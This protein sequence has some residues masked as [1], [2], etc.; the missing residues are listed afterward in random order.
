[1]ITSMISSLVAVALLATVPIGLRV[2]G[3]PAH[4]HAALARGAAA[5]S[6]LLPQGPLAG[7]LAVGW[8][9]AAVHLSWIR[10]GASL[11]TRAALAWLPA[12]AGWLV[13][14]RFGIP[15]LGFSSQIVALT[16]AHFHHAGFIVSALLSRVGAHR[17]L[18]VHQVGMVL[19]AAGITASDALEPLGAVCIVCALMVWTSVAWQRRSACSGWRRR[20]LTVSALAWL[21][22]MLLA[23]VWALAPF[24]P[25]VLVAPLTRTLSAMVAQHGAINAILLV[26]LGL[27]GL[28]PAASDGNPSSTRRQALT[29]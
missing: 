3:T 5:A 21:Y 11:P 1:M 23:L 27:V 17:A 22:P 13:A 9:L 29:R 4:R 19:V 26:L 24:G 8:L 15:P 25:G 16:A 6:L 2:L 14:D 20:A 18:A 12:A 7:L 28:T 10:R